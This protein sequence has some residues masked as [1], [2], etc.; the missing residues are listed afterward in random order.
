VSPQNDITRPRIAAQLEKILASGMFSQSERM[1]RFLRM[2]VEYSTSDR[3]D[4]LKEY[5]IGLQ[6][7]DRKPSFD[8]RVDPIV[9]VEAGRLRRKLT[10]YYETEGVAD[11][12][13]IELPKGTY[14]V[15]FR[16]QHPVAQH[17]VTNAPPAPPAPK[18]NAAIAVVPFANLS[19]GEESQ[20]F[21]DGLTQEL[22]LGLT[23]VSGL[24]V[25]AWTS[26]A[27]LRGADDFLS[28]GTR[29]NVG[30]ALTGSIRTAGDRV[31]V[32][33]QLI[34]TSDSSY[35]WSEAYDRRLSDL[36]QIQDDISRCIVDTLRLRLAH[37]LS[38][39]AHRPAAWNNEALDLYFKGRFAWSQRTSAGLM[40]SVS[41]LER[42]LQ[43]EPEFALGWAALADAFALLADYGIVSA[44]ESMPG[45]KQAALRAVELDPDLG[46]AWTSLGLVFGNYEWD[47]EEAERCYRRAILLN[48]GYS[49]V[50]QWYAVDH[51]VVLQRFREAEA[52][53]ALARQLDPWSTIILEGDAFIKVLQRRYDDAIV[54]YREALAIDPK[55]Y[56]SWTSIGR[57]L[58][59]QGRY[60]EAIES[61][62]RGRRLGGEIPNILGALGQ[63]HGLS[64]NHEKAREC[65]GQL[66]GSPST[67]HAIVYLG[68]GEHDSALDALE[69]ACERRESSLN[70]LKVH[71]VYDPLRNS[72]RFEAL[73]RR[74][75]LI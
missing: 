17:S 5:P 42:V 35:L 2:V 21:S 72:P 52:E 37:R 39:S 30:T 28:I 70:Q 47:R 50:H 1:C 63:A 25:V 60:A 23:R 26:A 48:P 56:K 54:V 59:Q 66:Q 69:R 51:L 67:S 74:I 8:P 68:L 20:Y 13:L 19:P 71:P 38:Y 61:L 65:L 40:L 4:E 57:A 7:F 55:F 15:R 22:I 34:D 12:I 11:E 49:T 32:T 29:L 64:G 24:R 46:E 14:V 75:G 10:K 6:V 27:Q 36:F 18:Q 43:L 33:A 3:A 45:A 73:L 9:R 41:L 62:E 53:I 58:I 44:S 16:R 31:R